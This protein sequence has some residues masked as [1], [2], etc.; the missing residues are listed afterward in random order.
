M[1]VLNASDAIYLGS[2][3]V[4]KA[5]YGTEQIYPYV[6]QPPLFV[7]DGVNWSNLVTPA[8]SATTNIQTITGINVTITLEVTFT[9][10][11]DNYQLQAIVNG[12]AM[13][14]GFVSSPGSFTFTVVNGDTVQFR[15]VGGDTRN[16]SATVT[17]S[18]DGNVVLDTF[19]ITLN[20]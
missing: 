13:A 16:S 8:N 14:E 17:N 7:P 11:R 9:E 2:T 12:S 15:A 18:S 10:D 5:Y 19:V 6:V 3:E 20:D 4:V 1:P